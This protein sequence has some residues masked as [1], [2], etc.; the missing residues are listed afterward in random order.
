MKGGHTF[1]SSYTSTSSRMGG[2]SCR[3][4]RPQNNAAGKET[5]RE[6]CSSEAG[7][8]EDNPQRTWSL[9]TTDRVTAPLRTQ[10]LR[11]VHGSPTRRTRSRR[12]KKHALSEPSNDIARL[13]GRVK[14]EEQVWHDVTETKRVTS[15]QH[16]RH[17]VNQYK[18]DGLLGQ[19]ASGNVL[20]AIDTTSGDIRAI[21]VTRRAVL[22]GIDKLLDSHN[23]GPL[24]GSIYREGT[25]ALT[26]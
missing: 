12:L 14:E 24:L 15:K 19:G 13:R 8:P 7:P 23:S 11:S 2:L 26:L 5:Y 25:I 17:K 20:R 4:K 6:T 22:R 18:F 16:P 3:N 21:K 1:P 10:S 9:K